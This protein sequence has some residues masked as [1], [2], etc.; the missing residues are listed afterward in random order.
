VAHRAKD[1]GLAEPR[2]R[3]EATLAHDSAASHRPSTISCFEGGS[4]RSGPQAWQGASWNPKSD[5]VGSDH[6]PSTFLDLGA[7]D[8]GAF[9]GLKSA[10]GR[11][12]PAE[13]FERAMREP[14]SLRI[15]GRV[16]Q[17]QGQELAFELDDGRTP[18]CAWLARR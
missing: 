18:R 9:I 17:V 14:L 3:H 16:D 15:V 2:D 4:Q 13:G 12:K 11:V 7:L 8:E 6:W 1:A 10:A 5:V